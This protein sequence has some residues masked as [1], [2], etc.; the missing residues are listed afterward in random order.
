MIALYALVVIVVG[1]I[2]FLSTSPDADDYI[3]AALVTAA[4][5]Y[6]VAANI[7]AAS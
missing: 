6:G 4:M 1:W 2:W 3:W 5:V 7:G